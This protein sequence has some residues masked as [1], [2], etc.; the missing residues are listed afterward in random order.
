GMSLRPVGTIAILSLAAAS[1]AGRSSHLANGSNAGT[2]VAGVWDGVFRAVLRD[3]VGS[4][5]TRIEKQEWH[6][7]QAGDSVSGYY[8]AALTFVSGDGRPYMCNREAQFSAMQRF[9]V[10]GQVRGGVV[11][12][13]EIAQRSAQ[14]RCDPGSRR[15]ARYQGNLRGDVLTLVTGEHRQTLYR[16]KE[17]GTRREASAADVLADAPATEATFPSLDQRDLANGAAPVT[18]SA[19]TDVSGLWVWEHRGAAPGGDEKQEREEWHVTQDGAK[20]TGYYDRVVHQVSIDGH[21][22]RCSMSLDF[23]IATRY[24][25]T[26]EVRGDQVII[27]ENSFEVL[28]PNACDNGKRRLDAYEGQASDEELRLVWGV[29]GQV[30]HRPRP[31]VPTQRF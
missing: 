27:Y 30:L 26:G 17:A 23:Q 18:G 19:P 8:I 24:Q 11:E 28:E 16:N 5:D 2:V 6:L 22:Y 12:I 7:S 3:G 31:D 9:D 21:A 15:L 29:G 4:G 14:G 1:C 25:I 13:Q 20:L 10:S